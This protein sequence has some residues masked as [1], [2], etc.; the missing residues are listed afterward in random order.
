[1][2]ESA[3]SAVT[4]RRRS[5]AGDGRR[6]FLRPLRAGLGGRRGGG[7][8][9]GLGELEEAA[10][11]LLVVLRLEDLYPLLDGGWGRAGGG[12]GGD[13]EGLGLDGGGGRLGLGLRDGAVA[14]GEDAG[15]RERLHEAAHDGVAR[16]LRRRPDG[17]RWEQRLRGLRA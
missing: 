2:R 16:A 1:M 8:R 7:G 14:L 3:P 9:P 10:A 11:D 4:F 15:R 12:L 17:E 13:G 5:G 6:R